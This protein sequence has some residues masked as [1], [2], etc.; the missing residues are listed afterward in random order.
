MEGPRQ[1]G[2]VEHIQHAV[3]VGVT[4]VN[5]TVARDR[6]LPLVLVAFDV[7]GTADDD[8]TQ[9]RRVVVALQRDQFVTT[10]AQPPTSARRPTFTYSPR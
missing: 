5:G 7:S 9:A 4:V 3:A 8:L 2:V 6:V 1:R 10:H